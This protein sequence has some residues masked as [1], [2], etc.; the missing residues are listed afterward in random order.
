VNCTQK[1]DYDNINLSLMLLTILTNLPELYSNWHSALVLTMFLKRMHKLLFILA[2]LT[3]FSGIF[4]WCNIYAGIKRKWYSYY[5]K[6][7]N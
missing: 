4:W 2:K 1:T 3:W 5:K 6:I 7:V